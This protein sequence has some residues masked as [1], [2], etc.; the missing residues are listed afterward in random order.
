VAVDPMREAMF[1]FP[2]HD[3]VWQTA[4]SCLAFTSALADRD[5]REA[6]FQAGMLREI[7][8]SLARFPDNNN[9]KWRACDFI[10]NI[11]SSV[12]HPTKEEV[13]TIHPFTL[14]CLACH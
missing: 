6:M 2:D 12:R 9:I 14:M 13:L 4:I 1:K 3:R 8:T 7:V 10:G 5:Q 11:V